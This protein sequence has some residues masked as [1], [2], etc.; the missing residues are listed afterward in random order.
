MVGTG[1]MPKKRQLLLVLISLLCVAMYF[2]IQ[3]LFKLSE[4][5]GSIDEFR[6][7]RTDAPTLVIGGF[8]L[9][10]VV[11]TT[12][13]L[14]GSAMLTMTSGALFGLV[15]GIGIAIIASSTGALFA[16]L[17]SRYLFRDFLEKR[18][19]EQL[20]MINQGV[21]KEGAYYLLSTRLIPIFPF[22]IVNIL[23]SVTALRAWTF[24][25]VS[26]LGMIPVTTAYVNAG[27]QL[28]QIESVAN[29]L[30]LELILSF[31]LLGVI[32]FITK[33]VVN[34]YEKRGNKS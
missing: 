15:E 10:Y 32:P 5:K 12:L 21:E 9:L 19:P 26:A 30:S 16:F 2:D 17:L 24:Y 18:F 31:S 7:W 20:M 6:Q 11:V 27:T 33:M 29:V 8:I 3:A 22:F 25:W 34:K 4:L 1:L 14:P 23:M 13:S 28:A